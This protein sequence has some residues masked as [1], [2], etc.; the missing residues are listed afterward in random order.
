[1][2]YDIKKLLGLKIKELRLKKG[3]TQEELSEK[4]GM[5]E[6]NLS[7]IE[8]G[9]NFVTADTL[10]NLIDALEIKPKD[11]FDFEYYKDENLIKCEIINA[12]NNNEIDLKILYK[13]YTALK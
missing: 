8:C 1:M 3:M 12:V 7:K 13:F 4:I 11:L 10:T 2:Q 6:R 9:K 5:V